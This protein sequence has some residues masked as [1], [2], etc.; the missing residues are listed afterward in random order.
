MAIPNDLLQVSVSLKEQV[1]ILQIRVQLPFLAQSFDVLGAH[2]VAIPKTTSG[3][4]TAENAPALLLLL[5]TC[6]A[7]VPPFTI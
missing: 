6:L 3:Q 1:G 5:H 4:S 2:E 7:F